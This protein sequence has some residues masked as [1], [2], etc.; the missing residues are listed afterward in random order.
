MQI[1]K[2]IT[3]LEKNK[4]NLI[5]GLTEY[6]FDGIQIAEALSTTWKQLT[7]K[8]YKL[9]LPKTKFEPLQIP[10]LPR[11][12]ALEKGEVYI[13]HEGVCPTDRQPL[14]QRLF[15]EVRLYAEMRYISLTQAKK[16]NIYIYKAQK[17]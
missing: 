16:G 1:D 7:E 11:L 13:Y 14:L 9:N 6:G 5:V 3:I 17:L 2:K 10:I 4:S 8:G 12:E 15:Y